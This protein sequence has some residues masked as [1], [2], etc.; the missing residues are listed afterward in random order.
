MSC[1]ALLVSRSI[2]NPAAPQ[3]AVGTTAVLQSNRGRSKGISNTDRLSMTKPAT[4]AS[5]TIKLRA[6]QDLD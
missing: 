2:R 6:F 5:S 3:R 1:L 4:D